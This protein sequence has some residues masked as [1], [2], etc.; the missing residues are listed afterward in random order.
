VQV[1]NPVVL[2]A[3]MAASSSAPALPGLRKLAKCLTSILEV[4]ALLHQEDLEDAAQEMLA[5]LCACFDY[6]ESGSFGIML[7]GNEELDTLKE[8]FAALPSLLQQVG[9][10]GT[11]LSCQLQHVELCTHGQC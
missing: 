7:Q 5:S 2:A 10:P 6:E 4:S 3:K 9:H 11:H 1:C 8:Q